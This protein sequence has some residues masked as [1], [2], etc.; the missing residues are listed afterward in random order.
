MLRPYYIRE[1]NSIVQ[2]LIATQPDYE[3]GMSL[4]VGGG[5]YDETGMC[6]RRLLEA[7]GLQGTDYVIDIGAGSGRLS[8]ALKDLPKLKYLGAD[9]V[10]QLLE[11]AQRKC[12]R[13]DWY[14]ELINE[15]KIPETDAVAD[16]VVFFSVFT[17][18]REKENYRYLQEAKRV[19]KTNGTIVVSF[20]EPHIVQ[21]TCHVGMSWRQPLWWKQLSRRMIGR[22]HLNKLLTREVLE[23]W[24]KALYPTIAYED[25]DFGQSVCTCRLR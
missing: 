17:H 1:F 25:F 10:L 12:G 22:G 20:L 3:S 19:I 16:F 9:V 4:A 24:A 14:F 5:S 2:H 15:I 8:Y 11:F 18:L 7:L 6:G 21:H 23:R 13:D